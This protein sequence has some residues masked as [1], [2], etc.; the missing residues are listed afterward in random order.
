[1]GMNTGFPASPIALV[2]IAIGILYTVT[3]WVL[4]GRGDVDLSLGA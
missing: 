1:M 3:H 4:G 2:L